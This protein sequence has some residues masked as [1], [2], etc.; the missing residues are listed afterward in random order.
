MQSLEITISTINGI[1]SAKRCVEMFLNAYPQLSI[2]KS[3]EQTSLA[4][5]YNSE[6]NSKSCDGYQKWIGSENGE[7]IYQFRLVFQ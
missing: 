4:D 7:E 5:L 2:D 1:V 6:T 3:L